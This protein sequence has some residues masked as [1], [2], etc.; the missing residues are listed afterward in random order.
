MESMGAGAF[1][2]IIMLVAMLGISYFLLIRPQ[3][4]KDREAN[5]MRN[6]LKI[7]DVVV[8]IGGIVGIVTSIKDDMLVLET[9]NDRNKV[10]V[11]KWAIQNIDSMDENT[12]KQ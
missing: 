11:K 7:G 9:G 4:K 6:S 12:N 10:R 3:K 5:E 1:M 8:T 2:P